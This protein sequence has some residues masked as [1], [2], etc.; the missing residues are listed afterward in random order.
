MVLE[1]RKLEV[2]GFAARVEQEPFT[3]VEL[4]RVAVFAYL[5]T[6]IQIAQSCTSG[7]GDLC[8]YESVAWNVVSIFMCCCW[9]CTSSRARG[10]VV[11][12]VMGAVVVLLLG[13]ARDR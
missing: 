3:V 2:R 13:W 7:G 1:N 6:G 9:M 4:V 11:V 12:V 8:C 5:D 10:G